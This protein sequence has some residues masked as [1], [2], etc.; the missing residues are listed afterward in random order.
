MPYAKDHKLRTR[1]RI[2][3]SA[4]TLFSRKGF[5]AVSIDDIMENCR[6]SR[7]G[8]YA[9]FRN[10]AE[11]YAEAMKNISATTSVPGEPDESAPPDIFTRLTAY[12]HDADKASRE[13]LAW[14]FLGF[15]VASPEPE[16]RG[17]YQDVLQKIN[18]QLRLEQTGQD[19]DAA[20]AGSALAIGAI[21]LALTLD[22]KELKQALHRA[23]KAWL[24]RLSD[25][26]SA[27]EDMAFFW[28]VDTAPERKQRAEMH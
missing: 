24:E 10:K 19:K 23:C 13:H 17:I 26:P 4:R 11:L 28:T 6:L 5:E 18:Q 14:T 12:L 15:D 21:A 7:G 2:L 22:S 3:K 16:V 1:R 8:F 9:H 27:Q 20:L 25:E